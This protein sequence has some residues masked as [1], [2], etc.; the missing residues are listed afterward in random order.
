MAG[1]SSCYGCVLSSSIL[2]Q[3]S[4]KGGGEFE[5]ERLIPLDKEKM[6]R[7]ED[8]ILRI[9]RPSDPQALWGKARQAVGKRCQS[10]RTLKRKEKRVGRPEL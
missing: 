10:L 3:S 1:N 9:Y 5:G 4:L 7:I 8:I 2:L 6:S